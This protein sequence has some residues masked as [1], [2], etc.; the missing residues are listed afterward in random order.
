MSSRRYI[1]SDDAPFTYQHVMLA[2]PYVEAPIDPWVSGE[3]GTMPRFGRH[4]RK[5]V[6]DNG[7]SNG[8]RKRAKDKARLER[9]E[10]AKARDYVAT[11]PLVK[12]PDPVEKSP[13]L[14]FRRE[15]RAVQHGPRPKGYNVFA[16]RVLKPK[17]L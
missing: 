17:E 4:G 6:V 14:T 8:A 13:R 5:I 12:E 11:L 1:K 3:E 2:G 16:R 15:G 7:M 9:V 10:A